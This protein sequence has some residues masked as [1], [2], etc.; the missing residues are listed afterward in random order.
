MLLLLVAAAPM[1]KARPHAR[2]YI[3]SMAQPCTAVKAGRAPSCDRTAISV[4]GD[5]AGRQLLPAAS[6]QPLPGRRLH[7]LVL[8]L[9]PQVLPQGCTLPVPAGTRHG[10]KT[11]PNR[12]ENACSDM[13]TTGIFKRKLKMKHTGQRIEG[14]RVTFK[15]PSPLL[16]S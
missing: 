14:G 5:P 3:S 16:Q 8:A 9:P 12:L 1:H 10:W 15:L 7:V 4:A 11:R 2:P 13:S 6:A